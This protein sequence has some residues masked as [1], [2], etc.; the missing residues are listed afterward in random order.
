MKSLLDEYDRV[1][2]RLNELNSIADIKNKE[3][4]Q[5]RADLLNLQSK[6]D[7]G[8]K[9]VSGLADEKVRWENSLVDLDMNYI[10]LIGDSAMASAFMSYCAP[11]P[12]EYRKDLCDSWIEKLVDE[13]LPY[14]KDYDFVEFLAGKALAREWQQNGLPTDDFSTENGVLVTKGLRWAL[15]IDP[16]TQA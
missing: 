4:E 8:D 11:F 14:S 12:A 5:L 9:L 13:N 7:R 16:Q 1:V 2:K 10:N 15:N 6:I 3:V